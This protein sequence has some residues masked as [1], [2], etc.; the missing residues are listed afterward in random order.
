MMILGLIPGFW[1][2]VF[3]LFVVWTFW[4]F[5]RPLWC[6]YFSIKS[7]PA[8]TFQFLR[9]CTFCMINTKV[10]LF[11]TVIEILVLVV[12]IHQLNTNVPNII[13]A[14][15]PFGILILQSP[16]IYLHIFHTKESTNICILRAWVKISFFFSGYGIV[17][18]NLSRRK[19]LK[20]DHDNS[21]CLN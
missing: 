13:K 8:P 18:I 1:Q 10:F 7:S 21:R 2:Q 17:T 6:C 20:A 3:L 16:H 4:F 19:S 11:I 12:S 15:Q 9:F 14:L 5:G